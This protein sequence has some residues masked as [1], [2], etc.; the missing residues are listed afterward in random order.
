MKIY[1]DMDGVLADFRGG[2]IKLCGMDPKEQ[3]TYDP[4]RDD[5]MFEA[6]RNTEG[7]Y[8]RLEPITEGVCLFLDVWEIY[9]DDCQILTGIPK[10]SR[11]IPAAADNKTA[12]AKR[13]IGPDVTVNAVLRKEKPRFCTGPD[14]ILIDDYIANIKDWEKHGGTGILYTDAG[15]VARKLIKAGVHIAKNY[16]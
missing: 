12:W 5:M 1:F 13:I 9:K 6:V 10:P 2:I 16:R 14:C 3:G 15:T 11:N 8:S 4:V 7:F